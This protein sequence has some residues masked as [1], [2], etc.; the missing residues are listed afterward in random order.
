MNT[1]IGNQLE[2]KQNIMLTPK[3][4]EELKILQMPNAE[5]AQYIEEA[6]VDNPM[7]ESERDDAWVGVFLK[8]RHDDRLSDED[9]ISEDGLEERDFTEYTPAQISLKQFLISQLGEIKLND[10]HKL[11][12]QYLIENIADDGYL[13]GSLVETALKLKVPLT[14]A[15]EALMIIQ[16]FEPSGVGARSLK[17]CILLQLKRKKLLDDINKKIVINYLD[18]LAARKYREVA[19]ILDTSKENIEKVHKLIKSLDPKPGYKFQCF[20]VGHIIP[21]LEVKDVSGIY[22]V[23]F[24]DE[25]IPAV[26]INKYYKELLT[27]DNRNTEVYKY[28]KSILEKALDF[29]HAIEQRKKTILSIANYIV[30]YHNDFFRDGYASMKPLTL[31]T[32]ADAVGVHESTVSRTVNNKYI[33][34]PRGIFE[35]KYFFSSQAD[36]INIAGISSNGAKKLILN[37]IKNEDRSNPLSDEQIKKQLEMQGISIARRTVAKY[38]GELSILPASQ[39]KQNFESDLI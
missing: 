9:L 28:V 30:E 24:H 34:T 16:S 8:N 17:E 4:M 2:Q 15:K 26:R 3:M 13:M 1:S 14:R 18:L 11:I 23:I 12:A 25:Y 37:I 6:L 10:Q 33:Q 20:H 35:L 39:R 31:K 38:R 27:K 19:K 5:L 22:A 21:E 7:L 32:A 29:I 36:S